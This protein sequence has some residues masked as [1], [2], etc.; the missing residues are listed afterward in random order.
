[1][2]CFD[3]DPNSLVVILAF[4]GGLIIGGVLEYLNFWLG[5]D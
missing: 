2:L 3:A 4:F 5:R 1:M